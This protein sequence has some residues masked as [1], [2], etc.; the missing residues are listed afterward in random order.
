MSNFKI[1][2]TVEL[3]SDPRMKFVVN[4]TYTVSNES[5]ALNSRTVVNCLQFIDGSASYVE[6]N[7]QLIEHSAEYRLSEA[8]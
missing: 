2:D 6:L 5:S 7:E 3:K 1:G 8:L 4:Y